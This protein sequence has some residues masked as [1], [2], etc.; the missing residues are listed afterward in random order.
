[1]A[2]PTTRE[3]ANK[4]KHCRSPSRQRQSQ[5]VYMLIIFVTIGVKLRPNNLRPIDYPIRPENLRLSTFYFSSLPTVRLCPSVVVRPVPGQSD[6]GAH[7]ESISAALIHSTESTSTFKS[8]AARPGQRRPF[9]Y[10]PAHE[11]VHT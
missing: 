6:F 8:A 5:V 2:M 7:F 10:Y 1:M 11:K 9:F 3:P 4:E